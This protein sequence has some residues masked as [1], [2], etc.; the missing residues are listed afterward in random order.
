[1]SKGTNKE[2]RT[3]APVTLTLYDL[4]KSDRKLDASSEK[5][6]SREMP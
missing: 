2:V 6:V 5:V 3:W 4:L 1:M